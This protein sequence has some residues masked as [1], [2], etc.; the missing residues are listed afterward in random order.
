MSWG[1]LCPFSVALEVPQGPWMVMACTSCQARPLQWVGM[2]AAYASHVIYFKFLL[3]QLRF[4][5]GPAKIGGPSARAL[6]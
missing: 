3:Y 5:A 4:T 1:Y 6:A 2:C